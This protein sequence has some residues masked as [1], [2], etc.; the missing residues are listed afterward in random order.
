MSAAVKFFGNSRVKYDE[1]RWGLYFSDRL[2]A[3][4]SGRLD[5]WSGLMQTTDAELH[6][7]DRSGMWRRLWNANPRL[8]TRT[9]EFADSWYALA[10]SASLS[11]LPENGAARTLVRDRERSLKGMRARLS[12]P[13]ALD[14]RR[15]YPTS[16]RLEFRWTQVKRIGADILEP[17][18]GPGV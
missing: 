17:L 9:R 10:T 15:G 12:Y 8:R 13:D 4:F 11:S 2:L 1:I 16:A 7:W 14:S 5:R 6:G 18:E 3:E